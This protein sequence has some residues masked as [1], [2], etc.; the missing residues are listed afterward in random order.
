MI[1]ELIQGEP[2]SAQAVIQ[3]VRAGAGVG[4]GGRGDAG[5]PQEVRRLLGSGGGRGG[6]GME[7]LGNVGSWGAW[8]RWSKGCKGGG[9]WSGRELRSCVLRC[10]IIYTSPRST[11]ARSQ[12]VRFFCWGGC[13]SNR[14]GCCY[15]FVGVL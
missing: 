1:Q 11:E 14:P 3:K 8:S 10:I 4:V 2:G 7:G 12:V 6:G 13:T 15:A 5:R 9:D